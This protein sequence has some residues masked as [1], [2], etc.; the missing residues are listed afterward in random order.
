MKITTDKRLKS[1]PVD[2][3]ALTHRIATKYD[4]SLEEAS[5]AFVRVRDTIIDCLVDGKTV[6]VDNLGAFIVCY[7][8]GGEDFDEY[9]NVPVFRDDRYFIRLKPSHRLNVL[10]DKRI[11]E[12]LYREGLN[13]E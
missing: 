7:R 10:V 13:N 1:K 8:E 9:L 2:G 11:K 5:Q 6:I 12:K 4:L 3:G